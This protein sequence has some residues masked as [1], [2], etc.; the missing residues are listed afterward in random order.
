MKDRHMLSQM[1]SFSRSLLKSPSRDRESISVATKMSERITKSSKLDPAAAVLWHPPGDRIAFLDEFPFPRLRSPILDATLACRQSFRTICFTRHKKSTWAEENL[2]SFNAWSV[3]SGAGVWGEFSLD[4]K[5]MTRRQDSCIVRN[6]LWMLD[7]FV[8]AVGR[9]GKY[10]SEELCHEPRTY[11]VTNNVLFLFNTGGLAEESNVQGA[12]SVL[13]QL[14]TLTTDFLRSL[15][16][17]CLWD[18]E[19]SFGDEADEDLV[20]FKST[21]FSEYDPLLANADESRVRS[22]TAVRDRLIKANSKRRSRLQSARKRKCESRSGTSHQSPQNQGPYPVLPPP[23]AAG[24]KVFECPH[25]FENLP[26]YLARAGHWREHVMADLAPYTCVVSE[27]QHPNL[28]FTS[29]LDWRSHVERVHGVQRWTCYYCNPSICF[30]SLKTLRKHLEEKRLDKVHAAALELGDSEIS[31]ETASWQI[32]KPLECPFCP[33]IALGNRSLDHIA[34]CLFGFA[35][36]A[37]LYNDTYVLQFASTF[38]GDQAE[39]LNRDFHRASTAVPVLPIESSDAIG[40][41]GLNMPVEN[42]AV[43]IDLLSTE[44]QPVPN[45]PQAISPSNLSKIPTGSKQ[46][47]TTRLPKREDHH[48]RSSAARGTPPLVVPQAVG[49]GSALSPE[50]AMISDGP[51]TKRR[52]LSEDDLPALTLEQ[53]SLDT[54]ISYTSS[55]M[56]T[57]SGSGL[58]GSTSRIMASGNTTMRT[59][60]VHEWDSEVL[61]WEGWESCYPGY[62]GKRD[63][64]RRSIIAIEQFKRVEKGIST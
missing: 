56:A 55:V 59:R 36:K 31:S 46:S 27:C 14:F 22:I 35:L 58:S 60:W 9:I 19:S 2:I 63:H 37:L 41:T 50:P 45:R 28:F 64:E 13:R 24:S 49:Q 26:V 43:P 38:E 52:K 1:P 20:L 48:S 4:D 57:I 8:N 34:N 25:C 40:S 16:I 10:I 23:V 54:R 30:D 62:T 33:E 42:I 17:T 53:Q 39:Q 51:P 29:E 7:D 61:P 5:L 18:S 44:G 15:P 21:L 47:S 3:S 11:S 12:E 32:D 6:L